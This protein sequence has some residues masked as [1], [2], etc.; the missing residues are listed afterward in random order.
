MYQKTNKS[1]K[2]LSI[3]DDEEL[4]RNAQQGDGTA[5]NILY[6]RYLP[7]VFNRVRYRIPE[8]DV[9]DVTQEVFIAAMRSIK[10]FRGKAQ[11]S[12]WLRT[13]TNRRIADYYR[14]RNDA[15]AELAVPLSEA[16]PS[17]VPNLRMSDTTDSTDD[18]MIIQDAL[19]QIPEH[20]QEVIL[21]RF[22]EGLKFKEIAREMGQSLEATK[23][24]FRRAMSALR[25]ELGESNV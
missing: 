18:K 14:S 5:F 4:I 20:Y 10:N 23:S 21:L 22:A 19:L 2:D 12:T 8:R 24:L 9:E 25:D 13:V 11:F 6:E 17:Y 3:L 15:E 1:V 16:H 7:G